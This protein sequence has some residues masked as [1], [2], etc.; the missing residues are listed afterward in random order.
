MELVTNTKGP[1]AVEFKLIKG[2]NTQAFIQKYQ[3]FHLK[4]LHPIFNIFYDNK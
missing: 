3:S 2:Y 4:D 1:I